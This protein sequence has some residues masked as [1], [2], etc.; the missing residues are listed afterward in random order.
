LEY[1]DCRP[2]RLLVN[3][4]PLIL[5]CSCWGQ[6]KRQIP[7]VLASTPPVVDGDISDAVWSSA[8]KATDFVDVISGSTSE[9]Q[10]TVSLLYDSKYL[11]IAFD[12][13][14][15]KPDAI[16]ARDTV[17]DSKFQK[18]GDRD[19]EDNVEVDFD[20]FLTHT[21]SDLSRFSVNPIGTRSAQFAGGRGHKAEWTGEWDAT[22][23]RTANGWT[24]E[25]RIPWSSLNYPNNRQSIT[26][27]VNFYRYIDRKKRL[28]EWSHVGDRQFMLE[29]EGLW[30]DVKVRASAAKPKVSL[31]PYLLGGIMDRRL[32]G[33]T[34]LD[35]RYPVTPQLTAVGTFN[36]DFSGLEAAIQTI[37][38]SSTETFLPEYRPFFQ[39]GSDNFDMP[40][41]ANI[42]DILFY[43]RRIGKFDLGAKMYG[44][45][46]P[47]D[48]IGL[49]DTYAY[50]GRNDLVFRYNR[51]TSETSSL[52]AMLIRKDTA[53]VEGNTL[54]AV[55]G[56]FRKGKFGID[57]VAA[58]TSGPGAGGG[59]QIASA[60]YQDK[61][62]TT[63]LHGSEASDD[64]VAPDSFIPIKGYRGYWYTNFIRYD[65]QHGFFSSA[66]LVLNAINFWRFNG[67]PFDR[68]L[69]S[70]LQ[71]V[72]RNDWE[73]SLAKNDVTFMGLHDGTLSVE[74]TKGF[75]NRFQSFG[76]Q[77]LTGETGGVPTTFISPVVKLRLFK[78]LDVLYSGAIQNRGGLAQQHVTTLNYELSPTRSFGG[79]IVNQ[80][81]DT[82]AYLFYRNSGGKGTEYYFI[83]GDPNARK[84]VRSVQLKVVFAF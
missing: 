35:V 47:H 61:H 3:V 10:T 81:A 45:L 18:Q 51:N 76:F 50:N 6:T 24:A 22:A 42:F 21:G 82:N 53:G 8:A 54:S 80:N 26:I 38:Y 79:R 20:P 71:M 34:G 75:H 2:T 33:K 83:L 4:V 46:S 1:I 39:E 32:T 56:E 64:F 57:A 74:L 31:L 59:M 63:I 44:K 48:G 7:G 62:V 58:N 78:K 16:V 73:F 70:S 29:N 49:L 23:K 77:V 27:G 43:S 41:G 25:M 5:V 13:R 36:P 28:N 40:W 14:D 52:G 37:A 84:T 30:T 9:D 65:W 12:C 11:Y 68:E 55:N 15:S 67:D 19:T 69:S 60:Y 72:T 17:R 66:Q